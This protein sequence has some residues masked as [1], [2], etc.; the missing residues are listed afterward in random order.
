MVGARSDPAGL[1]PEC[2]RLLEAWRRAPDARARERFYLEEILPVVLPRF[3][4]RP[5][6][7]APPEFRR[8]RFLVSLVGRSFRG[9][10]LLSALL[11]PERVLL[12]RTRPLPALG[13][14]E[15][16]ALESVAR[17]AGLPL[18]AIEHQ[19]LE[20][21]D[22]LA[23]A[24]ELRQFGH[25]TRCAR[26]EI[27]VDV[28]DG[29]GRFGI[30]AALAAQAAGA[31]LLMVD[32]E[33][34]DPALAAPVPFTEY[35]RHLG[36]P[37][38]VLASAAIGRICSAFDAGHYGDAATRAAEL[39]ERMLQPAE[40]RCLERVSRGY[41]AWHAFRYDEARRHLGE[42]KALLDRRADPAWPWLPA[43]RERLDSHLAIL[44]ALEG[45]G[46]RPATF[47]EGAPLI[48][49]QLAAARRALA[50]ADLDDAV[51]LYHGAVERVVDLVL[52]TRFGLDDR[53]PDFSSVSLDQ[54]RFDAVGPL[55]FDRYEPGAPRGPILY[56]NGIQLLHTLAPELLAEQDIGPLKGLGRMRNELVHGLVPRHPRATEVASVFRKVAPFWARLFGGLDRFEAQLADYAFPRLTGE[57]EVA[58]GA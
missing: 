27:A 12:L 14:R 7:G 2:R 47:E 8:P 52:W 58:G 22:D 38:A 34:W 26:D 30:A 20:Y 19:V 4:A 13:A 51:L 50:Q 31:R 10:A 45:A 41:G 11:K 18:D 40:A 3:V 15:P 24:E 35:P 55:V 48:L 36:D 53:N 16:S 33:R 23:V 37:M 54:A 1:D 9:A 49:S 39:A 6:T 57:A 29:E 28:T 56:R 25:R 5:L 43:V 32:H 42:A 46:P 44:D 21:E 17:A